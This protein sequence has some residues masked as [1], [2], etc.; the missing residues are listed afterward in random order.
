[1]NGSKVNTVCG[2]IS[3]EDMGKTLMHE[4]IVFGR[5]DDSPDGSYDYMELLQTSVEEIKAAKDLGIRT[6]IDATPGDVGRRPELYRDIMEKTGVNIICATGVYGQHDGVLARL[7]S[8][9]PLADLVEELYDLFMTE[10]TLG[11]AD[12]GIK[13]GVIKL[14]A[15]LGMISDYERACYAAAAKAQKETGAPIITHTEHGTMGPEQAKLLIDLGASPKQ[16]MIGHMCDNLDIDYQEAVLKQ[17]AYVSWDRMGIQVLAG[18]PMEAQ[19]HPLLIELINRGW[20]RQIM[21]SHDRITTW[22]GRFRD[23]PA[24]YQ[25]AVADW[26]MTYVPG[27][28]SQILKHGG[29]TDEQ[30]GNIL[31]G[32][33]ARLFAGA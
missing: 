33:P 25:A 32:N 15:G 30:L 10:L 22:L 3:P 27:K 8:P 24:K 12:S 23:I 19:R 9:I 5:P 2:A 29:V 4:H 17:G 6:I 31:R 13:P 16:L 18:C 20:D 21:F 28:L 7:G 14:V 1:M 26:H 11:I